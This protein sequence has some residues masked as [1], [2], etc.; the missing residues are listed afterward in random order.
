MAEIAFEQDLARL[1]AACE[2]GADLA[3]VLAAAAS[4]VGAALGADATATYELSEDGGALVRIE[5]EGPDTLDPPGTEPVLTD[6]RALCPLVSARRVLGCIVATG[7][8]EPDGVGHARIVAGIAAQAA[9]AAR[10]WAG[11]GGAGTVDLLTGLPN[12]LGFQSVMVRELSRAKRTGSSLAV[13]ILDLGAGAPFESGR[14]DVLVRAAS[15]SL[16]GAVRSY[17]CVCRLDAARFAL[18]LPG[19]AADAAAALAGRLSQTAAT[20]AGGITV[21]GG[22]AAFPEHAGTVD[23]LVSLAADALAG[24]RAAGG[25][26]AVGHSHHHDASAAT[27]DTARGMRAAEGPPGRSETSRAVGE[28][29]GHI[30]GTMGLDASHAER[31]RLAAFSYDPTTT[32]GD[33]AERARMESRVTA[34]VLDADAAEWVLARGEPVNDAPLETRI[35]AVADAFVAAGGHRSD[36][37]AGA[38][39][40]ELWQ[41]AGDELDASCVRALEL[42]IAS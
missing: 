18:V 6:G 20:A 36:A 15:G 35:L 5:G 30:A 23:D 42:L 32:A 8:T 40:A 24:A 13:A 19:M 25:G 39:L 22:V 9:E 41:R 12:H 17:D 27:P 38:A 37:A 16:A 34:G 11:A 4:A 3:G 26:V 7:V 31:I 14:G 21:A 2:A 10:L 28:Y 33:P 29:A 1:V